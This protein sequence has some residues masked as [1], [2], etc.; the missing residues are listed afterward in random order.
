MRINVKDK[1]DA[2]TLLHLVDQRLPEFYQSAPWGTASSPAH[3]ASPSPSA[4]TEAVGSVGRARKPSREL[5]S[6]LRRSI[7]RPSF[8]FYARGGEPGEGNKE[9][10]AA[11]FLFAF[12]DRTGVTGARC[13]AFADRGLWPEDFSGAVPF[14]LPFEADT[15]GGV[16]SASKN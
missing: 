2:L 11:A 3:A 5:F 16:S 7:G 10:E 15:R 12:F 1:H 14:P 9:G 6:T 8:F 4:Q 13:D